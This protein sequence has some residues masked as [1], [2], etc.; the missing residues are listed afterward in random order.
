MKFT[1]Y[2][3]DC[4]G[5]L[6][7]SIYPNKHIVTDETSMKAAAEFDHVT[8]EY[9]NNHRSNSDFLSSDNVPMDCDNDHS[10]DPND[11]VTPLEVAMAFP[12]VE[13]VVVYSRNHMLPKSGKTAR[14]RFHVYF[15]I[16]P[17]TESTEYTALKK[18]IAAEFPYFDNNALDSARLLFGVQNPQVEIFNGNLSIVD[19]LENSDFEQ[20]DNESSSVPEGSRN[21][22][23]S[24]YAGRIIKR[25]G[26]TDEA[27]RQFLKQAEK[28]SPPLDDSELQTIWNSAVK[29]GK[30]VSKQDGYIPPEQYNLGAASASGFNLKP[31][32][33]SD[34]GQA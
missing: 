8:A 20:W 16:S 10:D 4:I 14:P 21:S 29:F 2:T 30:K 12:G 34:I 18:Q 26:D 15:P 19:F 13:F 31:E 33:Y 11:W 27:Y 1:L 23:M 7:N 3:A 24:H 17:I 28:C 9:K 25:L 5:S 22:T 6:S 32:D